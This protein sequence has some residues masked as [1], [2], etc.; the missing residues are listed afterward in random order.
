MFLG[1][2]IGSALIDMKFQ[3][4]LEERLSNIRS[5]LRE[6]P[7]TTSQ[8]MM[9][10]RFERIKCNFGTPASD[11]LP[12]FELAVL[13]LP[14]GSNFPEYGIT[15]SKMVIGRYAAPHVRKSRC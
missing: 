12:T 3:R 6:D 2:P 14:P 5:H 4:W 1:Q 7:E 10:G 9:Q 13:G 8:R 11:L 15:G